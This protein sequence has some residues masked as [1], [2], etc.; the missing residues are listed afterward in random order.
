MGECVAAK[1]LPIFLFLVLFLSL[2]LSLSP[3]I[4][5]SLLLK[6]STSV[7]A[8]FSPTALSRSLARS[9]AL[10]SVS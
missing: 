10:I 9:V 1:T 2:S 4:S 3:S 5:L 7:H 8:I 6:T